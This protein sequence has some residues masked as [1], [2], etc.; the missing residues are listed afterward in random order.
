VRSQAPI[1]FW[2]T[3]LRLVN[4]RL[5][6]AE[7]RNTSGRHPV[8]FADLFRLVLDLQCLHGSI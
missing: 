5:H 8:E 2:W 1:R 6:I 7:L 4:V 3:R